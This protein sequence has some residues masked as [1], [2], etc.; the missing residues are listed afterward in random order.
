VLLSAHLGL[1]LAHPLTYL[2][3][4]GG[5]LA[6]SG[7]AGL[8]GRLWQ[9]IY[10]VEAVVLWN[11]CRRRGIRHLHVHFA[12]VSADVAMLV[13]AIG[14][15]AESS[16][17][18]SWSFTM[19]GPTEF[20]DVHRFRL[21]SKVRAAEFVVCISD[22]A[23]SQLM[24]LGG[25]KVWE[26]LHIV[27]VGIPIDQFTRMGPK[28]SGAQAPVVLCVGRLVADKGQ[29][30]LIEALS[31]LHERD[32]KIAAHLVLAGD[33]PE[34]S[35]LE[36]LA[37]D[38]GIAEHVSFLGSVGQDR[39]RGLYEAADIFC[40]PSFAEGVPVVLMEAMA[41]E[42]PV[43]TTAITGVPELVEDRVSGVLVRPGSVS[44][45][46]DAIDRLIRDAELGRALAEA[47]R[48]KVLDAFDVECSA[49]ELR[50]LFAREL[51]S[52]KRK[53]VR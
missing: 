34:R 3:T 22:Y 18:W 7:P 11:E 26:K 9:F 24:A 2:W 41:L 25:H 31:E 13:T 21:A 12:N 28:V 6:S 43:I 17:R 27:H 44:A 48:Q 16:Q 29:A 49:R 39:T 32:A 37:R 15:Q 50:Q 38:L 35:M 53:P 47:G 4:L 42:V 10:F 5:A 30:L 19:H 1:A 51:G 40:L 46:T 33:G 14:N 45:L 23:R 20:F 52:G 36:S 8:R